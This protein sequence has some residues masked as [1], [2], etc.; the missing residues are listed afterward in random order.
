[1][2]LEKEPPPERELSTITLLN[3]LIIKTLEASGHRD[4][5]YLGCISCGDSSRLIHS[6]IPGY[7]DCCTAHAKGEP[8]SKPYPWAAEAAELD[9]RGVRGPG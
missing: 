3:R 4:A 1:M 8:R 6:T 9:R 5:L 2:I 7:G